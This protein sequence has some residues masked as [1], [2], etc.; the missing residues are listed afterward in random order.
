MFFLELQTITADPIFMVKHLELGRARLVTYGA[1]S[2]KKK[3]Q[4]SAVTLE[5]LVFPKRLSINT[6]S[7]VQ[8]EIKM[9]LLVFICLQQYL[10]TCADGC[11]LSLVRNRWWKLSFNLFIQ[12]PKFY[13]F[14]ILAFFPLR[15]FRRNQVIIKDGK[16]LL[17]L[18]SIYSSWANNFESVT[19]RKLTICS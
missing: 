19:V 9:L 2:L 10:N 6:C 1:A 8:R 16:R 7:V 15:L 17:A 11:P 13:Y 12:I 3:V 14:I 18:L 5:G 4:S